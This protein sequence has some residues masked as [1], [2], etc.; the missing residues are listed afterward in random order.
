MSTFN[1][2]SAAEFA[3]QPASRSYL[4]MLALLATPLANAADNGPPIGRPL[5]VWGE[6]ERLVAAARAARDPVSGV[7]A[8]WAIVRLAPPTVERLELALTAHNPGYQVLHLSCHGT[9]EGL[10]I[11]DERGRETL[12]PTARLVAA[13]RAST[14]QLVV[15]NACDSAACGRA[16][17]AQA[18]V[19]CVIASNDKIYEAEAKLLSECL[20]R[21]L[22]AGATVEAALAQARS[23]I[24]AAVK[25]HPQLAFGTPEERAANLLLF[26]DGTLRLALDPAV[27]AA[28]EPQ[29]I[30]DSTPGSRLIDHSKLVGFVGRASELRQLGDWFSQTGRVVAALS[31]VGGQGKTS[32]ALNAALRNAWRFRALAFVSARDNPANFGLNDVLQALN[33]ALG[34]QTS[35]Q[36]GANLAG[37]IAQRLNNFPVLLLLDNLEVLDANQAAEL[38]R[39]IRSVAPASASRVLLTLRPADDEPLTPLTTLVAG[40]DRFPVLAL[41]PAA[42]LRLAYDECQR[43][44]VPP[45]AEASLD[46]AQR[47]EL[48]PLHRDANMPATMRRSQIAP[49]HDLSKLA[50]QH[51]YLIKLAA[52]LIKDE[53]WDAA[54]RRLQRLRGDQ[55]EV[56]LDQLIGIMIERV[57]AAAPQRLALLHAL[58]PFAGG[59]AEAD[60]YAVANGQPAASQDTLDDFADALRPLRQANLVSRSADQPPRYSFDPPL[61]Q[62]YLRLR[63][64][65]EP[66]AGWQYQQRHAAQFLAI[67][68]ANNQ[69]WLVGTL[70]LATL[71]EAANITNAI[72]W[73]IEAA[74]TDDQAGQMLLAYQRHTDNVLRNSY[75][76]RHMAWLER[77]LLV[78]Q[79]LGEQAGEANTRKAI[80]D[81]QQFRK[82]TDAAL[83][84]YAAALTLFQ[85]VGSRLGE[86]N[87]RKAIGDVQQ[88][89]DQYDAALASYAAAL[90]LF[91]A[92][93]DR[94]GEANTRQA[95]GDVQ[96]FRDQ[97][98]AALASYAAA[99]TLFQAVG[100]RLGEANTR[101]AI[102]DVQQFRKDTDA[103]LASYAA[104]LTLFQAVGSRLGE[105]NTRQA[106]GDVQRFRDQY[107]AALA[108]YAAALTLFQA[109]GSRLGEA[110]TRKAIGDVQQFRKDTD[111]ALASYAAALT[112]FQAV[113]SRLGEA[114][115]RKAIGDVQQFRDQYDAALASY[116]AALTLFQAVG[117]RLGEAN[118]RQ[119]I[120]DVQ[121]FRDQYDAALASYAAALTLFQ[122]VGSRLG[123]ANTRKAIG[124]VQQ[125]RD[126]YDAALASYAAALTLFQAVG[127]RLG[128]A[129]TRKA[130]GDVQQFRKDT[131]AALASYAAALTLFQ[132]VGD[133]LGE[134]NTRKAIGDVQQFRDQY[135]AALASYAA[136]LTLF[137]AVGDRL[138]EANTRKAIGDVQQFRKDTDAALASY[139]AALTLYQAVG[140]RVGEANT[141]AAQSRLLIDSDLAQSQALMAQ[142]AVL[143]RAIG[144]RYSEAADQGNYGLALWQ[145]G[146]NAEARP[147]IERARALL[148]AIGLEPQVAQMDAWLAEL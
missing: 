138:G 146:R 38:A 71:P 115:T 27:P 98:D 41:D 129:N 70:H 96:Q 94:L 18:G 37:A 140:E 128:E 118:T 95:I 24:A 123:E 144:D 81:V 50:F 76:P 82:D 132:A 124:D 47:S 20:Y 75:E 80:G 74:Q 107:D 22:A 121:Q 31:G 99:L 46:A 2:P 137:Q 90:T 147:Y 60:L 4:R 67:A 87:T 19:A 120:G 44:A 143:R 15:L 13:L 29:L 64:P 92:V 9:D 89:R 53:G 113:G 52:N 54:R 12:L 58:L 78:A 111:A 134:A 105:A 68:E 103:A 126:Q 88:F 117:D 28:S 25:E 11:E 84:S 97:Y 131:D 148:A 139:A 72:I 106:I 83:A 59:A 77:I 133:R 93:G 62:A 101:K 63:R 30:A 21:H 69:N 23:A 122:A 10:L 6:W 73:L 66:A 40:R 125:F 5:D 61:V 42:A 145:R 36:D 43:Q 116:A 127:S 45:P 110:N 141:L 33:E 34:T 86:A 57:C 114:N 85:A 35:A 109:V 91:Q 102:G 16:L 56:A 48:E 51:T 65:P 7:G 39:A 55:L 104:A 8:P 32:L 17:V 79:R 1:P 100:D 3:N 112:L 142:A 130:I 108:S 119:A 135:D 49:Y 26:G 136:A 14:V